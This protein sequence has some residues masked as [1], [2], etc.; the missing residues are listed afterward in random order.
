[1]GK[2]ALCLI[3]AFLFSINSFAA[4]V[5]DNDGSAFITKAEFE[6]MKKDFDSQIDNYN[7]S[8]DAKIDGAIASYLAGTRLKRPIDTPVE[9]PVDTVYCM[10]S[11][12]D[13]EEKDLK[14]VFSWPVVSLEHVGWNGWWEVSG[15]GVYGRKYTWT[16]KN[17]SKQGCRNLISDTID[18]T[19]SFAGCAE[20]RGY[21]EG[22]WDDVNWSAVQTYYN[23]GWGFHYA[24]SSTCIEWEA[25]NAPV[26]GVNYGDK[27]VLEG[28]LGGNVAGEY[29]AGYRDE[30]KENDIYVQ[31]LNL[32][33]ANVKAENLIIWRPERQYAFTEIDKNRFW[34]FDAKASIS[35]WDTNKTYAPKLY[36]DTPTV[37]DYYK[38]ENYGY[39]ANLFTTASLYRAYHQGNGVGEACGTKTVT[40][41]NWTN[42]HKDSKY[43]EQSKQRL[44]LPTEG[45]PWQTISNWDQLYIKNNSWAVKGNIDKS[46]SSIIRPNGNDA[47]YLSVN[48]GWPI[49]EIKF[50]GEYEYVVEFVEPVDHMVFAKYVPFTTSNPESE[51]TIVWDKDVELV[52]G[53]TNAAKVPAGKKVTLKFEAEK[54]GI[55]YIK[56]C[57]IPTSGTTLYGGGTLIASKT[58]VKK[59]I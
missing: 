42:P 52:P 14:Y 55:L 57:E 40:A 31:S 11:R 48:G 53:Y 26:Y 56:W 9:N 33:Y 50:E 12:G 35:D 16:K 24:G 49:T 19:A 15:H 43:Y 13:E 45:F 6:A 10:V 36:W 59:E 28:W 37:S 41:K 29:D 3:F 4:V 1:M 30:Y 21:A 22:A 39:F 8:I 54:N 44:P 27:N 51:E 17:N 2:K 7:N 32:N 58:I 23:Y 38:K 47:E 20:W 5:S 18:K 25:T 34:K 46:I